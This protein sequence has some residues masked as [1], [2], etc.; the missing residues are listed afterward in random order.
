MA[1]ELDGLLARVDD[2]ALRADLRT[3]IDRL[4]V[5][6]SFGLV[7][8]SH[9]PERVRLPEHPVRVGASVAL[10]DD[11]QSATYQVVGVSDGR[12]AVRQ[13]RRVGRSGPVALRDRGVGG[14]NRLPGPRRSL[15]GPTT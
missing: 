13:V 8:E 1:D 14:G 5:K 6:R 15:P 2:D 7:F 11:P 10:R 12:A 9:L 3:H 4:R